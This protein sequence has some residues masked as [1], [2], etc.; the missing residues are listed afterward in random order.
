VSDRDPSLHPL[1]LEAEYLLDPLY[2]WTWLRA[3]RRIRQAQPDL[4][5]VQWWTTF[6]G[7]AYAV[8]ARLL[9]GGGLRLVYVVHNVLPH[10]QRPWDRPLA[11]LALAQGDAFIVQTGQEQER[12]LEL[13]PRARALVHPHPVYQPFTE[14]KTTRPEA[15]RRLGLPE[16]GG[17]LLFFGIVRPYKG[18]PVLLDALALLKGRGLTPRLLIAGEFWEEKAGY[19]RQIEALGLQDQVRI[20]DRYIP[21][22]EVDVLFRAADA[23]VAP[24]TGGTQS[25]AANLGLGYGLPMIVTDPVAS[26]LPAENRGAVFTARPGDPASL[27]DALAAF[28]SSPPAA[29]MP[30]RGGDWQSLAR[31][32]LEA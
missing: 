11:R 31:A 26:G 20:E 3:A 27:A 19:L 1:H 7:P 17:V 6:W 9:R 23:L 28:L 10:E 8:L 21:N 25:G 18:L 24:Y 14:A 4:V 15:R 30:P 16:S 32:L 13:L 2:P 5:A 29:G 22:E 12:L